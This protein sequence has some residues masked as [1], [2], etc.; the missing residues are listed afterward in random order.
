MLGG[1]IVHF[2]SPE[3][4]SGVANNADMHTAIHICKYAMFRFLFT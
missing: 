1:Q 4:F 3:H 2:Y